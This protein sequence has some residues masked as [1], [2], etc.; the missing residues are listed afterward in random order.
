MPSVAVD[1]LFALLIAGLGALI[2]WWVAAHTRSRTMVANSEG[3]RVHE[4]LSCLQSLAAN[5]A[6]EIGAHNTRVEEINEE[7][8]SSGTEAKEIVAVVAKLVD[9]NKMMQGRLD[10]AEDRIREQA[11]IGR[12]ACG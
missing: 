1:L 5:V 7:L 11:R 12:I 2:G 9:A 3:Q 8:V 6:T 4:V 10:K